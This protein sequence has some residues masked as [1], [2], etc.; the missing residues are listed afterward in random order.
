MLSDQYS[1]VFSTPYHDDPSPWLLFPDEEYTQ[2][3]ICDIEFT[4]YEMA[5]AMDELATNAAP[6]PDGFPAILLQK[7]RN[8]LAPPLAKIWRKSMLNGE[9]PDICKSATII[10]IHKGKSRAVPKNYR[11]VAL[12]S[13][14]IKIFKK[15]SES[16]LYISCKQMT[17][18]TTLSMDSEEEGHV[19][20]SSSVILIESP[21][22]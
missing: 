21:Q 5:E 9:I 22:S 12:T 6:G 3:D 4:D 11:P 1:S 8:A 10:P 13:H 19:S 17:S 15:L 2:S 7:C 14:L 16:I 20:V 18:S